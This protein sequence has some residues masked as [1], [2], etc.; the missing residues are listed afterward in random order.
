MPIPFFEI[1]S[2]IDDVFQGAVEAIM[3]PICGLGRQVTLIF[4]PTTT[5]DCPNCSRQ[6]I[7][8]K[9]TARYNASNPNP[10]G[11]LN[12]SFTAGSCPVCKGTGSIESA[13]PAQYLVNMVVIPNPFGGSDE[14]AALGDVIDATKTYYWAGGYMTDK[15]NIERCDHAIM[16]GDKVRRVGP[17]TPIGLKTDKYIETFWEK[18]E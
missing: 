5:M 16:R 1:P 8:G 10:A 4:K 6:S 2:I 9:S 7:L 3:H 15:N 14:F 13:V 17:V 11:P 18:F 12:Q